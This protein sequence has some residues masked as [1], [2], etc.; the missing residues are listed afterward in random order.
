M[1]VI[2]HIKGVVALEHRYLILFAEVSMAA[3]LDEVENCEYTT[4]SYEEV[5]RR[6]EERAERTIINSLDLKLLPQTR[7]YLIAPIVD[8][9][10]R[11]ANRSDGKR[12]LTPIM[13]LRLRQLFQPQNQKAH[14]P[15]IS[16]G[17]SALYRY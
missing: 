11:E 7:H 12:E 2:Y 10:V 17:P 15:P 14:R 5:K 9:N 6:E 13:E 1:I 16:S 3:L 8:S 4:T